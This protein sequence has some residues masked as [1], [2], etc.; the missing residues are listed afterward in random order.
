MTPTNIL[1]GVIYFSVLAM[2]NW[3]CM[4]HYKSLSLSATPPRRVVSLRRAAPLSPAVAVTAAKVKGTAATANVASIPGKIAT[5]FTTPRGGFASAVVAASEGAKCPGRRP[6]HT[7]LTTQATIYQQW[8]SRI[9]YYHWRKQAA[10][11]GPCT[12]MTNFTRLVA[13]E[14]GAPD[15]LEGEIPSIFV[16]QYTTAEIARYGHFGVLN[17]PFSVQQFIDNGGLE[18]VVEQYI[19]IAETDHVLMKPLPNMASPTK[20]A[21]FGFGYMHSSSSVQKFI[22]RVAPGASW[23]DVQPVGPSPLIILSSDL[24]R[25]TPAWLNISLELKLDPQADRRFGWVLEMW[26]YSIAAASLG[27]RHDVRRDFQ[28]C[29]QRERYYPYLRHLC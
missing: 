25:L 12:E 19:Y 1:W 16:R 15:G 29:R 3:V 20:A 23:S 14:G 8:Q 9:M 2:W 13:S 28:V 4:Q 21:A 22:D 24:R 18:R 27:I 26:G 17:R 5:D 10:A 11:S 7:L 6:F